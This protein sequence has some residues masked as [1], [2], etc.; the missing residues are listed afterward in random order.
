MCVPLTS[1]NAV[2]DVCTCVLMFMCMCTCIARTTL[3]F[4]NLFCDHPKYT[5]CHEIRT[6]DLSHSHCMPVHKIDTFQCLELSS[7]CSPFLLHYSRFDFRYVKLYYI[8][9]FS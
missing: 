3:H 8:R 6:C 7:V 4:L 5:N 9:Y 2:D 1:H